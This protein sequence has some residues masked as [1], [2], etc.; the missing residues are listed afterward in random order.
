VNLGD[1]EVTFD[2]GVAVR[3]VLLAS[4]PVEVD[5]E[6]LTVGPEAFAIAELG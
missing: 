2:L 6:A 1:E 5:D 4:E 3:R